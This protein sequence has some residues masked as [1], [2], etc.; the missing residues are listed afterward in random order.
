MLRNAIGYTDIS[1]VRA[2]LPEIVPEL[3]KLIPSGSET[4][5][6]AG[7]EV[8][9][10]GRYSFSAN[11][12]WYRNRFEFK[13]S[14]LNQNMAENW[15]LARVTGSKCIDPLVLARIK[16]TSDAETPSVPT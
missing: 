13:G 8:F 7:I 2:G 11:G 12:D 3:S 14:T 9:D 16:K 15:G 1:H 10:K 6:S 4:G 5:D